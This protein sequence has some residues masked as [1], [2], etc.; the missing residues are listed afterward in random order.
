MKS[1]NEM[2]PKNFS[3][4]FSDI[5]DFILGSKKTQV[6]IALFSVVSLIYVVSKMSETSTVVYRDYQK[7]NFFADSAAILFVSKPYVSK[8]LE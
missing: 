4:S 7:P 5:K 6:W 1:L 8:P 2:M 3:R